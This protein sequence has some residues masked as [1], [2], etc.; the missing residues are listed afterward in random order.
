MFG[1]IKNLISGILNF[2][3]GLFGGKKGDYYL[4]LDESSEEKAQQTAKAPAKELAAAKAPAKEL[5]KQP[6][7]NEK[8]ATETVTATASAKTNGTQE[9]APTTK[10]EPAKVELV[11]TANGVRPEPAKN[12]KADA[13]KVIQEQPKE[14]TFAP[15][16]LA[17]P[18][19]NNGRRRP[20]A[21][22]NPFLDMARQVKTPAR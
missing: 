19:T 5:A 14:T 2:F 21:N 20:G 10:P 3:I 9:A 7:A 22:M 16:Y 13:A 6:A 1:F 17:V 4:E 11:Q 12:A 15:Q 18:S 8:T